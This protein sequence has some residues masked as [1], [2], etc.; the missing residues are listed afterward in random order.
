MPGITT[1]Y[2]SNVDKI[3]GNL[4]DTL[5]VL[6]E[7][8]EDAALNLAVSRHDEIVQ[9][10][11][12]IAPPRGDEKFAWSHDPAA[13][14]RAQK[15]WFAN[16]RKGNIP[17]DG[18]HYKRQGRPGMG[19]DMEVD[20]AGDTIL[21]RVFN[22]WKKSWTVFG[23]LRVNVKRPPI[24]GHATTGWQAANPKLQQIFFDMTREMRRMVVDAVR[25][26]KRR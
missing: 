4:V 8:V 21:I 19:W 1:T 2:S 11:G 20:R 16:L 26:G 13:N 14:R 10:L 15:W 9:T 6:P 24:P 3:I 18:K 17:T 7:I 12:T 25:K 22:K 5:T 23:N